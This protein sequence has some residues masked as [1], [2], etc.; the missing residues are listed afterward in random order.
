MRYLTMV[1]VIGMLLLASLVH[2]EQF[3]GALSGVAVFMDGTPIVGVPVKVVGTGFVREVITGP[4]GSFNLVTPIGKVTASLPIADNYDSTQSVIVPIDG[5]GTMRLVLRHAGMLV[6]FVAAD[7]SP[8]TVTTATAAYHKLHGEVIDIPSATFGAAGRWFDV[9]SDATQIA[10]RASIN[11]VDRHD[12]SIARQFSFN[13]S[14]LQQQI[15][16][17]LPVGIL[18]FQVVDNYGRPQGNTRVSGTLRYPMQGAIPGY[19]D[20]HDPATTAGTQ[21]I[22]ALLTDDYGYLDLGTV[23][24]G[25]YRLRLTANA[26]AGTDVDFTVSN[27][28]H[29]SLLQY[30]LG[31]GGTQPPPN[32]GNNRRV[33]QQ[34]FDADGRPAGN[35]TVHASYAYRGV[36][37][38]VD[39]VTDNNGRVTWPSLPPVRVIVWG[40]NVPAGVISATATDV[41]NPLPAPVP[42]EYIRYSVRVEGL[43]VDQTTLT[44]RF[45]RAGQQRGEVTTTEYRQTNYVIS[46]ASQEWNIPGGTLFDLTVSADRNGISPARL[47]QVYTPYIDDNARNAVYPLPMPGYDDGGDN[48]GGGGYGR[49]TVRGRLLGESGSGRMASRLDIVSVDNNNYLPQPIQVELRY[50][51]SFFATLPGVGRYRVIVD[52]IDESSSDFPG[53]LFTANAGE[54]RVD[55]TLPDPVITVTSG[56]QVNWVTTTDPTTLHSLDA[57]AGQRIVDVYGDPERILVAWFR[58]RSDQLTY[59]NPTLGTLTAE[60]TRTLTER[61]FNLTASSSNG[62]DYP[63]TLRLLPLFPVDVTDINTAGSELIPVLVPGGQT[64][65]VSLLAGPYVFDDPDRPELGILGRIDLTLVRG[66]ADLRASHYNNNFKQPAD[67]RI[68]ELIF[69]VASGN[70]P[71]DAAATMLVTVDSDPSFTVYLAGADIR[72][73]QAQVRVPIGA[74]QLSIQ[75]PGVGVTSN[76]QIPHS[77]PNRMLRIRLP[78]RQPGL[79]VAGR[80]VDDAGVPLRGRELTFIL[81]GQLPADAITVNTGMYG[82]FDVPGLLIGSITAQAVFDGVTYSWPLNISNE[83]MP[84]LVLRTDDEASRRHPLAIYMPLETLART[85]LNVVVFRIREGRE[86]VIANLQPNWLPFSLLDAQVAQLPNV[87]TGS[88]RVVVTTNRGNTQMNATVDTYGGAAIP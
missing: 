22:N 3:R 59:W 54:N 28:G 25:D 17:T 30:T 37:Y 81:P 75:W 38:L 19:W 39:R 31:Y 23:L 12:I 53:M 64:V 79:R 67:M 45:R 13:R 11:G 76:V 51:G 62:R 40:N 85:P 83:V 80:L 68:L 63:G 50:D 6:N 71:G 24:P 47:T 72:N 46:G 57:R 18:R 10:V 36:A 41:R 78:L 66:N 48:N 16:I 44:W 88:Y 58:P 49:V 9:S 52:M 69:P 56:A 33:M 77:N 4:D 32:P 27:D 61:Y 8:V 29:V 87:K 14:N 65:R 21:N 5:R 82:S 43:N 55:I 1:M 2:A 86:S 7:G 74:T 15:K 42:D 73:G 84:P 20:T 60:R 34:V 70:D 35:T 26:Q